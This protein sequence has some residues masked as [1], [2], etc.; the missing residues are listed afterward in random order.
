MKLTSPKSKHIAKAA[1][2]SVL[3]S[4]FSNS[5]LSQPEMKNK[6]IAPFAQKSYRSTHEP[7]DNNNLIIKETKQLTNKDIYTDE[8]EPTTH[9]ITD[10][11]AGVSCF[12]GSSVVKFPA[13]V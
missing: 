8:Q 4:A 9:N 13:C 10:R 12:V 2:G 3:T 7:T 5:M 1:Q 6:K 11:Q